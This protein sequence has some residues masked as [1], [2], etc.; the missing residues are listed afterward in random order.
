MNINL[1]LEGVTKFFQSKCF[2]CIIIAVIAIIVILLAF[3]AGTMVGFRRGAFSCHWGDNYHK[4]FGGPRGGFSGMINDRDFMPGNGIFGQIIKVEGD[5]LIIKG[6]DNLEK[7]VLVNE[8]TSIMKFQEQIKITDLKVDDR[9][10]IMGEPNESGQTI[11]RLIRIMP[12]PPTDAPMA[13]SMSP[14]LP[15]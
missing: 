2:K 8:K 6:Q 15:Q 7:S 5:S 13:P 12:A 1:N 4:N 11:A 14:G 10:V 9:V 3:K